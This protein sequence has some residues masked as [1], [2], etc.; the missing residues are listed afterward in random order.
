MSDPIAEYFERYPTFNFRPSQT[1]WRQIGA[2]NA[3]AQHQ[4]WSQARRK[5]EFDEFKSFWIVIVE[6]EFE[7]SSLEHYQNLCQDLSISP[8]P[9][10]ITACKNALRAVYVNIVDLM[11]YRKDRA[12][13]RRADLPPLFG[14]LEELSEY[15]DNEKK[16]YPRETAKAE[17]L[18]EL[19]KVLT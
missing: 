17:M 2:F 9:E 8:I 4:R 3:L 16:W 10:S 5:S 14:S 11:Q 12:A 13:G 19:L 6:T 18:R 7:D 15:S 1:D